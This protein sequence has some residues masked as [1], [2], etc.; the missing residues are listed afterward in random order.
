[1]CVT[2]TFCCR[3]VFAFDFSPFVSS[4]TGLERSR[5]LA[6]VSVFFSCRFLFFCLLLTYDIISSVSR[7]SLVVLPFFPS[8]L[9]HPFI[10]YLSPSHSPTIR[11]SSSASCICLYERQ[12]WS[13]EV[14]GKMSFGMDSFSLKRIAK[15]TK[16][17]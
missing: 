15:Q 5:V 16:C 2:V 3:L 8:T 17:K 11:P 4:L 1:M 14:T 13:F 9:I 10:Y 12:D 6:N 7:F